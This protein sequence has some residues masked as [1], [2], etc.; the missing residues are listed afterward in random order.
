MEIRSAAPGD[1][2]LEAWSEPPG[3]VPGL[4]GRNDL[5]VLKRLSPKATQC[6]QT[7]SSNPNRYSSSVSAENVN[8]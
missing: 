1:P 2:E 6:F 7:L 5:A 3:N 4:Q 8:L